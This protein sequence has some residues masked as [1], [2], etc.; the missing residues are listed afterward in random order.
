MRIYKKYWKGSHSDFQRNWKHKYNLFLM[1]IRDIHD[2]GIRIIQP[3]DLFM[4]IR[5]YA[6]TKKWNLEGKQ[7]YF[8]FW[9]KMAEGEGFLKQDPKGLGWII[10]DNIKEIDKLIFKAY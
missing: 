7:M 10:T 4:L 6:P 9:I 1:A 5:R 3:D 8:K 2:K